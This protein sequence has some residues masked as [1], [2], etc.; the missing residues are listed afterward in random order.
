MRQDRSVLPCKTLILLI[1][2]L[3]LFSFSAFTT[4]QWSSPLPLLFMTGKSAQNCRI[5]SSRL[6]SA[7]RQVCVPDKW[8]TS[9]NHRPQTIISSDR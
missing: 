9:V 4:R 7:S 8:K 2:F 6:R 1:T 5:L 3:E